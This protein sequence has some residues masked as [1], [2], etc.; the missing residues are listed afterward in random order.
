MEGEKIMQKLEIARIQKLIFCLVL[1]LSS[2][3][4]G[5]FIQ[6]SKVSFGDG[7]VDEIIADT[8]NTGTMT[9]G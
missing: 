8:G 5:I 9:S 7:T 3:V 1:V 4:G 6:H 2:F